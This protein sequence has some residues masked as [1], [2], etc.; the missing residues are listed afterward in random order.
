MCGRAC[1]FVQPWALASPCLSPSQEFMNQSHTKRV[2]SVKEC[3][4][5]QRLRR[6]TR[7]ETTFKR[8][9]IPWS[10]ASERG[11]NE[12]SGGIY[13]NVLFIMNSEHIFWTRRRTPFTSLDTFF[14]KRPICQKYPPL[15][16]YGHKW[17]LSTTTEH[18]Y[19][20]TEQT[21]NKCDISFF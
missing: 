7:Q 9:R 10:T 8:E 15:I 3:L 12:I 18:C 1:T 2:E 5:V 19:C 14:S 21:W 20:T 6:K 17:A 11:I 4:T 13:S 16:I